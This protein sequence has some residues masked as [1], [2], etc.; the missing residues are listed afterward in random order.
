MIY[1]G[2]GALAAFAMI[3]IEVSTHQMSL[4]IQLESPSFQPWIIYVSMLVMIVICRGI[5]FVAL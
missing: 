1:F 5:E 2:F 3:I 4:E